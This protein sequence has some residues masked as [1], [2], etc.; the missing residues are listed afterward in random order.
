MVQLIDKVG[1]RVESTFGDLKYGQAFLGRGNKIYLKTTQHTAVKWD[2]DGWVH[3]TV[4]NREAIQ[5]S[6]DY[7]E[8]VFPYKTTITIERIEKVE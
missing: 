1:K 6:Y 5:Y 2:N 8:P 4:S 3:A 7:D